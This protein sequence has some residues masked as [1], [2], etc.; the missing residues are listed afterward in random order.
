VRSSEGEPSRGNRERE[1]ERERER[2]DRRERGERAR[3][4]ER[5]ER[6]RVT[7]EREGGKE[8]FSTR[9]WEEPRRRDAVA[10]E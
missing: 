10:T 7:T 3:E 4:R 9:A 6:E 2:R 8:T 5:R 1:R